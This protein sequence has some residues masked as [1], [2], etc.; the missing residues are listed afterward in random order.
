MEIGFYDLKTNEQLTSWGLL[1]LMVLLIM[2]LWTSYYLQAKKIKSIHET[3]ISIFLGMIVGL[4]IEEFQNTDIQKIVTFNYGY[5]FNLL[6]PPIILNSGYE[7]HQELFF[8][9]LGAIVTFAFVGTFVS[10]VITGLLTYI[11]ALTGLEQVKISW[12]EALKFGAT[13]SATDPVTIL[14][15]FRTYGVDPTLYTI[16]FGESLLNDSVSIVMFETLQRFYNK[17]IN[18]I[19]VF[20]GIGQFFITFI[21]SLAIGILAGIFIALLLKYSHLRRF[22]YIESCIITLIA[23]ASYL[24]SNGCHMSGIVSLLFCAIALKHY[25]FYN[26]STQTQFS[27]KFLFKILSQL[28]ENFI[29]VYL[30]IS[31]F[32][33]TN[34]VYKPLL[35][36]VTM[37]FVCIARYISI[38][39]ISKFINMV[40]QS[41]NI[42]FCE[43]LPASYQIMLFW[44]GLRGAVGVALIQAVEGEAANTLKA[45]ILVLVVLTVIIFGGTTPQMLEI[46]GIHM[47][48]INHE[49]DYHIEDFYNENPSLEE[50]ISDRFIFKRTGSLSNSQKINQYIYESDQHSKQLDSLDLLYHSD[51]SSERKKDQDNIYKKSFDSDIFFPTVMEYTKLEDISYTSYEMTR[52][53]IFQDNEQLY[54]SDNHIKWFKDFDSKILM[55]LVIEKDIMSKKNNYKV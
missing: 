46:V 20:I 51:N 23:Y 1:I 18:I 33:Q 3:V 55:P 30:G 11:W 27:T 13:I 25:A 7:L 44:S 52:E 2:A 54:A 41:Y 21:I 45:T 29:F 6:L 40:M 26:M 15:I 10:A 16:I 28:S 43:K 4:L 38:F 12:I 35:I 34:L 49:D 39:S 53:N 42:I 5:F 9:N 50:N 31:L 37:F 8:K 32:T 48:I 14:S 47:G 36:L 19:D 24:F 17:E 22:P